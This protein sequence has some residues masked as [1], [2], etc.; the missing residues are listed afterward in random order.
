LRAFILERGRTRRHVE[1]IVDSNY[2][3]FTI[4]RITTCIKEHR[5]LEINCG[6]P[7]EEPLVPF[8]KYNRHRGKAHCPETRHPRL[9]SDRK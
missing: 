3:Y 9:T 6:P 2:C 5:K 1:G 8:P 4:E 7:D